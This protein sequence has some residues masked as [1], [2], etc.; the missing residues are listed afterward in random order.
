LNI[1]TGVV[2]ATTFD[3]NA[4][5]G[6]NGGAFATP[7]GWPGADAFGGGIFNLGTLAMTNCTLA[8]NAAHGGNPGGTAASS[9]SAFGG[10]I[11]TTN[12][13]T[14]LMNTTI[15]S[16]SVIPGI[17]Y[18]G[19][20]FRLGANIA[21]TNGSFT[22]RNSLVA[23]SG[24]NANAWGTITDGGYNMSSDGSAN[25]SGGTSFNFT[26]PKLLPLANNG[27]PTLTMALAADSPAIDWAPAAG[28]PTTDQRGFA[29]PYGAGVDLGAFELGPGVPSLNA[30]RTGTNVNLSFVGQA[31]VSYRIQRSPNLLIWETE[32]N[33]GVVSTNGIVS[34]NYPATQPLRFYRLTLD[35]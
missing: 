28:A 13:M 11:F 4:A 6:G 31:G 16:N 35:F 19:G 24:T 25:F 30:R 8:L 7:G 27:G 33:I 26:N 9:G 15:A 2:H 5:T 1:G 23:Y 17:Y 32:E 20:G 18:S 10:G 34:R 14:V 29:R 21:N 12:G 3:N 22:L